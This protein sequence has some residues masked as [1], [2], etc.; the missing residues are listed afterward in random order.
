MQA[1]GQYGIGLLAE[2]NTVVAANL[3][4]TDAANDCVVPFTA[5]ATAEQFVVNDGSAALGTALRISVRGTYAASFHAAFTAHADTAEVH[6]GMT[7][8]AVAAGLTSTFALATVGRFAIAG[9]ITISAVSAIDAGF[10]AAGGFQIED[11]EAAATAAGGAGAGAI[12]RAHATIAG[13]T[14]PSANTV[15]APEIATW[16]MRIERMGDLQGIARA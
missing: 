1:L 6:I 4:G 16:V 7:K 8:N 12:I 9:P 14:H 3:G 2:G 13:D 15:G 10:N 11:S 5:I